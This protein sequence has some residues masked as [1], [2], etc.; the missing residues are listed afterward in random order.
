[1]AFIVYCCYFKGQIQGSADGGLLKAGKGDEKPATESEENA[2][3]EEGQPGNGL[4]IVLLFS[5]YSKSSIAFKT[6]RFCICLFF[7]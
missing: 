5:R 1:M 7:I 6:V 3:P 2:S 4:G